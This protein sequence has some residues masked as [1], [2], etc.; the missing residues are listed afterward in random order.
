MINDTQ[1]IGLKFNPDKVLN[2]L[3][4]SLDS[5]KW[6]SKHHL[7]YIPNTKTNLA[8]VYNTF[9]GV[10][11]IDYSRFL[12]NKPLNTSNKNVDVS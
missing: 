3:V 1:V 8:Q 11:W 5:P 2:A 6:S 9:N 4:K 7:A 10:A 12:N